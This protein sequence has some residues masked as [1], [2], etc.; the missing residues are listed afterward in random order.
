MAIQRNSFRARALVG[1]AIIGAFAA[2]PGLAHAQ[3]AGASDTEG[4]LEEI[5]V[6]AQRREE[7][8]QDVPIAVSAVTT[9]TLKNAGI[10]ST[11]ELT[12]IVPSVQ[13][14]RSGPS[15][16]FFIRGVGTTNA[17]AGEE[18]ANALYIDNVYIGDL[19][20][21]FNNFNN[22]ARIEVL[23]G[24]QGTL[25]G[26]NATG[27][28]IHIITKEPGEETVLQ[29]RIGLANYE[30]VDAQ[31]YAGGPITDKIGFDVALTKRHQNDGWGRNLTRNTKNQL[32]DY[33]G[34]RSKLVVRPTDTIKLVLAGDYYHNKDN[35]GLGWRIAD[36]TLAQNFLGGPGYASP[37]GHDTTSDTAALT[38]QR[39]WGVSLTAEADLGFATL[40]S[41]TAHRDNRNHSAFDVDGGPS[42][43]LPSGA[44]LG[45]NIDYIST[46]KTWQQELRLASND[47]DPLSWQVGFFYLNS[48]AA[49]SPQQITGVQNS[50]IDADLKTN[51]YAAFGEAT[52]AITPTTKLTG[53]VRYTIDKRDFFGTTRAILAGGVL[54]PPIASASS[55]AANDHL[56]TKE[57]SYR[58]ALRQELTDDV[59]VYA[60]VNRGFKAGTYNLQSPGLAPALPQFIMA[61]EAGLKSELFD[62]R[63]RFNLAA[64]HYKIDDFQVR[65]AAVTS[66]IAG[67]SQLLNAATVKVDGIDVDF[68]LAAT[69]QLRFF[70]GATL[71]N[72][73][74]SKFG[75]PGATVQ[76][77]I[78]YLAPATCPAN[79]IG[80]RDP[81]VVGAGPRTGGIV[82]CLGDVSGNKLP[83]SPKFAA[84]IG[85]TY[86]IPLGETDELRASL[87][88]N[89]NSGYYFEPDNRRKQGDFGLLNASIEYRVSDNLGLEFWGKNITKTAYAVQNLSTAPFVIAEV[90]G[91]P[92]TYG[93]NLNFDF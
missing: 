8:L 48:K 4:G 75:G 47:T 25:F 54:G 79:L 35:L 28:L 19:G 63:L 73:R 93:V 15:G 32:E 42:P 9:D 76:A 43:T 45:L 92:R 2:S 82:A 16:L 34:I 3:E 20:Q 46:G 65:S 78:V 53:G 5:I 29:G 33:W 30:T 80:T 13:V 22:I 12:Q 36:G 55:S 85:A 14:T 37:G 84:S 50:Q 70:G 27:G 52:Y 87:L 40:T 57:W 59:S 91:A 17:A 89:Y 58:I 83:M 66:G 60:S 72:S 6:T 18:G 71:L 64:Y 44:L 26:R 88:Y 69:D 1:S 67:T 10:N 61:Y 56:T 68:E 62:R 21:M 23:K 74:F 77:P 11:R 31:V 7:S 86:T 81:G 38:N 51:S 90:L 39:I 24:P 49:T 41:I